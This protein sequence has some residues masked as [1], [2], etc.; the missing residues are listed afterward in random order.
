MEDSKRQSAAEARAAALSFQ[1]PVS[2]EWAHALGGDLF[3]DSWRSY[4]EPAWPSLLACFGGRSS[5][6]P[7]RVAE[8]GFGRGFNLAVCARRWQDQQPEGLIEAIAFEAAPELLTPWP[9]CPAGWEPWMP[10]WGQS[11]QAPTKVWDWPRGRLELQLCQAQDGNW[12]AAPV[13]LLILDLFSPNRHPDS[14]NPEL[15]QTVAKASRRGTLITSYSC[16]RQVRDGL[17]KVGFE[18]KRVRR[19]GW[20]DTLCGQFCGMNSANPAQR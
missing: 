20:R 17:Q 3:T 1:H 16:A 7:L 15:F 8:I 9:T 10:W 4:L 6:L 14:W 13:D 11:W 2:G 5:Q 19:I 18:V 12:P